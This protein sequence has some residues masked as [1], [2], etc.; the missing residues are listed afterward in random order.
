VQENLVRSIAKAIFFCFLFSSQKGLAATATGSLPVSS[1]VITS[2]SVGTVNPLAFGSYDPT[3][4]TATNAQSTITINCTPLT[5]YNV[6]LDG[7]TGA[8][9]SA[10]NP[11]VM[12]GLPSGT[13]NY[14]LF[15]NSTYTTVWGNTIGVNTV[16]ES[17]TLISVTLTVY[18]QIAAA[19]ASRA[20]TY[21]DTVTI[22]VT[23]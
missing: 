19:Q 8:G 18:G 2:C 6:G 13:L 11:R 15:S 22:T 14:S 1:T 4:A 20:G 16:S 9:G 7:G 3:S 23:Y 12:T 17:S 21:S 5:A 10:N